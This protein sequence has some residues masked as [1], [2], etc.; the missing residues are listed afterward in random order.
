MTAD[1]QPADVEMALK[2][3]AARAESAPSI[4]EIVFVVPTLKDLPSTTLAGVLGPGPLKELAKG[5]PVTLYGLPARATSDSKFVRPRESALVVAVYADRK[6]MNRIDECAG[7]HTVIAVPHAPSALDA[8][9]AAWTPQ[10]LGQPPA[11]AP[12]P[13]TG[14]VKD[15]VVLKALEDL[16]SSINLS[17]AA[18]GVQDGGRAEEIL[19]SLRCIDH[20][21][22]A[23]AHIRA[24][25]VSNG[26]KPTAADELE[27][28]ATKFF[29][30]KTKPKLA[31]DVV[32]R[33]RE[34]W[35]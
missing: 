31:A 32:E 6:T 8:W 2:A 14:P 25:A 15:D 27:K 7:V 30:T 11:A 28:M 23:P 24:W 20:H 26:W 1:G 12:R 16:T 33:A 17:T 9:Q 13:G 21:H 19:K 4:V 22:E 29:S 5:E 35:L 3:A 10:V 18:L 34:R